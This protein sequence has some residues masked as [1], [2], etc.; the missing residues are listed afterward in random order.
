[1]WMTCGSDNFNRRSW[2]HDSELTCAV[3]DPD[4]AL[5]RSLRTALWSEHLGLPLEDPRLADLDA[6]GALWRERTL[7]PASPARSHRPAPVSRAARLWATPMYRLAYDSDGR[8]RHLR[9]RDSF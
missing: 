7:F 2:T 5:P 6:A 9:R 4:G 3:V 8:P 1:M